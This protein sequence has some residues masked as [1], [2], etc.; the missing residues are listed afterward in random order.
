MYILLCDD[1]SYYTGSTRDLEQ[2]L[3][4]HFNGE[5]ANYTRKHKPV[6][7]M[8]FEEFERIDEAYY[9]ERQIHGWSRKKKEALINHMPEKIHEY[10]KCINET[11]YKISMAKKN[12][13]N[14]SL[15]STDSFR[16]SHNAVQPA[17]FP[18][19]ILKRDKE[20]SLMRR[21]PWV[22]SGAVAKMQGEPQEG[23][24]VEIFSS[25]GNYLATAHYQDDSIIAKVFDFERSAIDEAFWTKRFES[26]INYRRNFGFFDSPDTNVFRLVNGEGDFM[27]GL[28][29]DF[30]NGVVVFQAH[31]VGMYRLFPQFAKIVC[32]LLGDRVISIFDKSSAT[33]P[34]IQTTDSFIWG[35]SIEEREIC[36]SGNRMIINFYEGQKTGFF[37]DQRENRKL[38]GELS[39]GKRVLNTFGYT[40]GFSLSA[41]RGGASYVE[42]VDISKKAIALCERNVELNFADAP[43]KGVAKDVLDYLGTIDNN[44]DIIILDPP[45]FAKNHRSLQQ[46]LKGYKNINQKA[47][48]KIKPG[49]LIF[50]FSCSQAVSK[51]DFKTMV[52]TAAANAHRNVRIVRQ[53][54]HAIDH[55]VSIY[56][57]EGEYL[58]GLMIE[59]E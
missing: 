28:I 23:D 50:T 24:L 21:H 29:A 40:G 53:L 1:G 7:L 31:S 42:T 22:F 32:K 54:P 11:H 46:G 51:D 58:K 26:A 5:G 8:Y 45:A 20:K 59:V 27:P 18:K 55:P 17:E 4:D 30:Y 43:H 35:E 36:E 34:H 19:L 12:G 2:R 14:V 13:N 44:F 10:A 15:S 41:L 25:D 49:G 37:V 56:H 48:E 52:F 57:P 9:R 39:S 47:I 16:L 6:K 3:E 33:I 38:V